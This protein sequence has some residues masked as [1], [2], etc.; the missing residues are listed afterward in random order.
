MKT[1]LLLIGGFI[2]LLIIIISPN[3]KDTLP[4]EQKYVQLE[5]EL[6]ESQQARHHL[7]HLIDSLN[8][9]NEDLLSVNDSLS[10]E[11][12]KIKGRYK[13]KTTLELQKLMIDG[14]K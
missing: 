7:V 6:K 11:L 13:T 12:G 10:G 8:I 9:R 1:N 14:A 5:R 2:Y 3:K 4:L